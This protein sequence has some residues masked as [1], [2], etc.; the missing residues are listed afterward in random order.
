M[1]EE[2][3]PTIENTT[4]VHI[5]AIQE[6]VDEELCEKIRCEEA[7]EMLFSDLSDAISFK[8]LDPVGNLLDD[9]YIKNIKP[10]ND[11]VSDIDAELKSLQDTV[12]NLLQDIVS[13]I[14]DQDMER[15][16]MMIC[17]ETIEDNTQ[18]SDEHLV[19]DVDKQWEDSLNALLPDCSSLDHVSIDGPDAVEEH[20]KPESSGCVLEN[21][22]ND[23]KSLAEN[24]ITLEEQER[25]SSELQVPEYGSLYN[26]IN[27]DSSKIWNGKCGAGSKERYL[28]NG[29]NNNTSI[30]LIEEL[31]AL[32]YCKFDNCDSNTCKQKSCVGEVRSG[33]KRLII[34]NNSVD[35]SN[36][37][38]YISNPDVDVKCNGETSSN[39]K[40]NAKFSFRMQFNNHVLKF[41][42]LRN[43]KGR[44]RQKVK[45]P[46]KVKN[47][48]TFHRNVCAPLV[49][50]GHTGNCFACTPCIP[51]PWYDDD[52][53]DCDDIV[54]EGI[55]GNFSMN[56]NSNR[57]LNIGS[58]TKRS[59]PYGQHDPS[60]T[61]VS[62]PPTINEPCSAQTRSLVGNPK[63][64]EQ[65][66]HHST[67]FPAVTQAHSLNVSN[68]TCG[69]NSNIAIIDRLDRVLIPGHDRKGIPLRC[70]KC[71]RVYRTEESFRRH[72]ES[73]DFEIDSSSSEDDGSLENCTE[74]ADS[75]L[76]SHANAGISYRA[77]ESSWETTNVS[78]TSEI[79]SENVTIDPP[80]DA[81]VYSVSTPDTS[82]AAIEQ[83]EPFIPKPPAP[84]AYS[85]HS[86]SPLPCSNKVPVH[87]PKRI[88]PKLESRVQRHSRRQPTYNGAM[89]SVMGFQVHPNHSSYQHQT[90]VIQVPSGTFVIPSSQVV[91]PAP[92]QT[93]QH[94]GNL[95]LSQGQ[96]A[97]LSVNIPVGHMVAI[98]NVHQPLSIPTMIPTVQQIIPQQAY[99]QAP[100]EV[101]LVQSVV[102]MTN[103]PVP[104]LPHCVLAHA[105]PALR[106]VDVTL[107]S[108]SLHPHNPFLSSFPIANTQPVIQQSGYHLV[109]NVLSQEV[110]QQLS[111]PV[112]PLQQMH[113]PTV[114]QQ[115]QSLSTSLTPISRPSR[116]LSTVNDSVV[117]YTND[118]HSVGIQVQNASIQTYSDSDDH[119][120]VV[121]DSS[122]SLHSESLIATPST[123][124]ATYSVEKSLDS[125]SDVSSTI[126]NPDKL[127]VSIPETSTAFVQCSNLTSL[128]VSNDN[129]KNNKTVKRDSL[130]MQS[131]SRSRKVR[132]E[133]S[134]VDEVINDVVNCVTAIGDSNHTQ[135]SNTRPIEQT[136]EEGNSRRISDRVKG[137]GTSPH[138]AF[139]ILSEDGFHIRSP[140]VDGELI[141][142]LFL[143]SNET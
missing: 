99:C 39:C 25:V 126:L 26:A 71:K 49:D 16:T 15:L 76:S 58:Q 128:S 11:E 122:S 27:S 137:V 139:E 93:V 104:Q 98:S 136:A 141:V 85:C 43:G 31:N 24:T 130:G 95:E 116:V 13:D 7:Y 140:D 3:S 40:G 106:S 129:V 121:G 68:S 124:D 133:H 94:F 19:G 2:V 52:E 72:V 88:L 46:C 30:E 22:V 75:L 17:N 38:N 86:K 131:S 125:L 35:L 112:E 8:N 50:I 111:A 4:T 103:T 78:E 69:N 127:P 53:A 143:F 120:P 74:I 41:Y 62:V 70:P 44:F 65:S 59:I 102:H 119:E 135:P 101:P 57:E 64:L 82:G 90:Q 61:G 110:V 12:G 92:V 1:E 60:G 66:S 55:S 9:D 77:P 48:G 36:K 142:W 20:C 67:T 134:S 81:P 33:Q 97:P 115:Q 100:Q 37:L 14:A 109:N 123:T 18:N 42:P 84:H 47:N 91:Q 138:I 45:L 96:L 5:P 87:I 117:N 28:S 10:S 105:S 114:V 113:L 80:L 63:P 132:I 118:F 32:K 34:N 108:S 79:S 89:P 107:H 83:E 56:L 23:L 21:V 73:C 29:W 51:S 6:F 54:E